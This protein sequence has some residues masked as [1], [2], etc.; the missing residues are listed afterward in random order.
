MNKTLEPSEKQVGEIVQA[1]RAAANDPWSR[2][3]GI[4][5]DRYP[6]MARAAWR[7]IAPMAFDAAA[8]E[9]VGRHEPGPPGSTW[10][11]G[12]TWREAAAIVQEMKDDVR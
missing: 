7:A 5:E 9:L 4:A 3:D 6:H 1:L 11:S 8:L 10:I 2:G 12:T